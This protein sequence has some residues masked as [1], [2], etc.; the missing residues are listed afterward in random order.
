MSESSAHPPRHPGEPTGDPE[1]TGESLD[2]TRPLVN[3]D[4][5]DAPA[6]DE[7]AVQPAEPEATT[8]EPERRGG[9]RLF[10]Q[11]PDDPRLAGETPATPDPAAPRCREP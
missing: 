11:L 5:D 1:L 2:S 6:P 10:P 8:T 3:F 7:P 9:S 4:A